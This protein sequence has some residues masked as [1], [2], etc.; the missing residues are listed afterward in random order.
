[1]NAPRAG[2]RRLLLLL[3]CIALGAAIGWVGFAITD[4]AAWFL[5]I[6][7]AIAAG[8]LVVA[9]PTRCVPDKRKKGSGSNSS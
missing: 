3:A 5:A 9:D 7:A 4:A 8:W 1:M 6:P 2:M